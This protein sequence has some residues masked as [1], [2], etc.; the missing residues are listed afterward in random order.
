M[1]ALRVHL[2]VCVCTCA[3]VQ[4]DVCVHVHVR[5]SVHVCA[6]V[7]TKLLLMNSLHWLYASWAK[8]FLIS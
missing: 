3:C 7:C 8:E 1:C 5:V 6:R 2:S 4:A